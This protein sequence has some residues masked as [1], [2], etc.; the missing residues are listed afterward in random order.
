[1]NL[2]SETYNL[3]QKQ[4]FLFLSRVKEMKLDVRITVDGSNVSPNDPKNWYTGFSP[5]NWGRKVGRSSSVKGG[6]FGSGVGIGYAFHY[7]KNKNGDHFVRLYNGGVENPFKKDF[8]EK[9]KKDVSLAVAA[10]N[11]PLPQ[12]CRIWP[13]TK[14]YNFGFL[15][16][17][18]ME[19]QPVPLGDNASSIILQNYT[20]LN[21]KYNGLVAQFLRKYYEQGAF[22]VELDFGN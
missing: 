5:L 10:H 9:F 22:S 2:L 4:T 3:Y 11:I 18:L 20:I 12:G 17:S 21:E 15:G 7:N 16:T 14:F 13:D 6:G 1:M 19:C 8:R